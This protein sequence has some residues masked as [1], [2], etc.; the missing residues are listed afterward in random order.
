MAFDEKLADRVRAVLAKRRGIAERRMFGGIAFLVRGHM[1]C[2]VTGRDLM[3]RVGPDAYDDALARPHARPMDFTGRPMR[4]LVYVAPAGVRSAP[5][6]RA[7]VDR[8]VAF[9]RSLPEKAAR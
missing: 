4:G 2:G 9:T 1:A 5:A 8:G 7:W 3:V 6:L